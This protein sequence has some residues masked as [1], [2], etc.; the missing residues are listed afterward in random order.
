MKI[1]N[2]GDFDALY[3]P[4]DSLRRG[5]I[6][7]GRHAVYSTLCLRTSAFV[8]LGRMPSEAFYL[9]PFVLEILFT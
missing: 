7:Q 4:K 1:N 9:E 8:S 5:G 6:K 3:C 2:K